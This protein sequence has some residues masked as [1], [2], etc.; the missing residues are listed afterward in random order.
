MPSW[1]RLETE[2]M[3]SCTC[4]TTNHPTRPM[5]TNPPMKVSAV[6]GPRGSP[7]WRSHATVGW[8]SAVI[9]VAAMKASTT[10]SM[11]VMTRASTQSVA[12]STS[13][14]QPASAATRTP[15]GTASTGSGRAATAGA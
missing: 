3:L 10:S 1:I 9:S 14:R 8:S 6:D 7:R 4:Q 12:A 2:S 5:T 13:S 15:H 11:V